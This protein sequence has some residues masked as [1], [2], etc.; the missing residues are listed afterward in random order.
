MENPVDRPQG[1][2]GMESVASRASNRIELRVIHSMATSFDAL[3]TVSTEGQA[4]SF[5]VRTQL[6][7]PVSVS[8]GENIV[9][10]RH[11]KLFIYDAGHVSKS[12]KS[13]KKPTYGLIHYHSGIEVDSEAQVQFDVKLYVP[14][15]K[16]HTIWDM[17]ARGHLPREI[18][19]QVMGLR[20][21]AQWDIND[22]GS[23]LL[24]EDFSFSYPI[25]TYTL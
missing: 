15:E 11:G 2:V 16:Y 20:G 5:P 17:G 24:I 3:M 22:V 10:L 4:I 19:L 21:D 18:S 25:N 9:S 12:P 8:V 7:M 1:G 23:M 13:T 6:G 14:T